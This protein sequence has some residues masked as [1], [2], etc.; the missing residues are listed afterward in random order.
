MNE[1]KFLRA[2][3]IELPVEQVIKIPNSLKRN[4]I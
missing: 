3:V 1:E 2:E 4:I